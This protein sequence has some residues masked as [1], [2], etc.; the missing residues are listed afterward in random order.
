RRKLIKGALA[1]TV[2]TAAGCGGGGGGGGGSA[3]SGLGSG[4]PSIFSVPSQSQAVMSW[5]VCVEKSE[6]EA[7]AMQVQTLTQV[8]DTFVR[9]TL[10]VADGLITPTSTQ[11]VE[12]Q[13][14]LDGTGRWRQIV[15]GGTSSTL[16]QWTRLTAEP[17]RVQDMQ[18]LLAIDVRDGS[19]IQTRLEGPE[20]NVATDSCWNSVKTGA[21]KL[22]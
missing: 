2:V 3:V 13:F 9:G 4:S 15:N 8:D 20:G 12:G 19:I 16:T 10:P 18:V 17:R 11:P 6:G 5:Q 7:E 1:A 22:V 14:F 21:A